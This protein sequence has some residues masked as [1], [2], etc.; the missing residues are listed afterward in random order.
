MKSIK[1]PA[2][3]VPRQLLSPADLGSSILQR[4]CEVR[5]WISAY[6]WSH[7]S[8]GFFTIF[9]EFTN[10]ALQVGASCHKHSQVMQVSQNKAVKTF[11][12]S[13]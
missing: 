4:I 8:T 7:V 3:F 13:Q 9:M 10:E 5:L 2:P 11:T 6:T 12:A 1:P